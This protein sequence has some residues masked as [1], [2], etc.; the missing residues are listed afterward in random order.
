MILNLQ[1]RPRFSTLKR[2]E[3]NYP[4]GPEKQ[5]NTEVKYGKLFTAATQHFT[6]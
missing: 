2:A 6:V 4:I 3:I 5:T 1:T